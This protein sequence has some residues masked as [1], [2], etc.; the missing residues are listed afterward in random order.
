MQA[1][2]ETAGGYPGPDPLWA[3]CDLPHTATLDIPGP[4]GSDIKRILLFT[5][6]VSRGLPQFFAN[7][8]LD[9]QTVW[10]TV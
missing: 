7:W 5:N 3:A 10:A 8:D 9:F 6:Y 1:Q 2:L 4:L